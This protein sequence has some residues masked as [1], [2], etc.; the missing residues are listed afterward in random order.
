MLRKIS[1]LISVFACSFSFAQTPG[2]WVWMHG[3]NAPGNNGNFGTKGVAAPTNK[4]PGLYEACEWTDLQGNFWL[5]GGAGPMGMYNSLWKFEPATNM[6]TWVHGSNTAN[7]AAVYG[8]QGVPSPTNSPG[9]RGYGVMSVTDLN[10]DLWLFGGYENAGERNDLWKYNIAT[11][12][13]TW[14]KGPNTAMQ[15]GVFGTQGVSSPAN[16]PPGREENNAIWCD[17]QNNIWLFGGYN[18]MGGSLN[19]LWKYNIATNEWTWV[20][21][22]QTS[23]QAVSYGVMNVESPTNDPGG[24]F[25]YT[26]FID[27]DN[28]LYM[29]G[30]GL[31]YTTDLRNDIWKYNP[32]TNNWAWMAGP[33]TSNHD[34]T[35]IAYCDTIGLNLPGSKF[36]IR[37]SWSDSCGFFFFGGFDNGSQNCNDLW[38]Y[39]IENNKFTWISGSSTP[40]PAANYGTIGVSAPTNI[41][42]GRGGALGWKDNQ[43]NLWMFGGLDIVSAGLYCNDMWRYTL[44]PNCVALCSKSVFNTNINASFSADNLGC[45][46]HSV[47]F[48]NNSNGAT[49]YT[50]YFGDGDT[51]TATNPSHTYANTGTYTV[52]LIA[53]D[54][55]TCDTATLN[56]NV[57][58][59]AVA[60]FGA[61]TTS[62]CIPFTVNMANSST[63]AVSYLWDFGDGDTSTVAN[64]SHIYDTTG[65]FVITLIAIGDNGCNDTTSSTIL[66]GCDSTE[67]FIPNVFTPNGDGSNDVFEIIAEGYS[68]FHL[69]VY[70]RWGLRMFESSEVSLMWNGKVDNS[71]K[72]CSEGTYYY[73]L[74]LV[75]KDNQPLNYTGHVTLLRLK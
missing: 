48:N 74:D 56:I 24:R 15:P 70:N 17:D 58:P 64:P 53:C 65:T 39:N 6:W 19:D 10:G 28:N 7:G 16:Y 54:T 14:M 62:E 32:A 40:N 67:L 49:S 60:A 23:N 1:I 57:V 42:G 59:Y 50:W 37:A 45:V 8:T 4:P 73:V 2:E 46:P 35:Y 63:N 31:Q 47:S 29:F 26:K 44:D 11:N 75:D 3:D 36:E 9:S 55:V 25:S 13:W 5:Y 27:G 33:S 21:G 12:E 71:G 20:D 51:S 69:R 30:A 66:L 34:G 52:M 61:S 18:Q 72:E 68:N 41:P 43:G 38:Y 22:V